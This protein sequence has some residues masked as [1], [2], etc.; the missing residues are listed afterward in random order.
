MLL[1]Q[2]NLLLTQLG[3]LL[4]QLGL[5]LTYLKVVIEQSLQL[6]HLSLLHNALPYL[7]TLFRSNFKA[8]LRWDTNS[9]EIT[10]NTDQGLLGPLI[11][12]DS[13]PLKL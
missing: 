6:A 9:D 13:D 4:T 1:T 10:G 8:I 11:R 12:I 3:L 2:L 5:L 7:L